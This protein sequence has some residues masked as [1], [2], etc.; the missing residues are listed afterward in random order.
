MRSKSE[1]LIV[2]RVLDYLSYPSESVEKFEKGVEKSRRK[3]AKN[4]IQIWLDEEREG[5]WDDSFGFFFG[6]LCVICFGTFVE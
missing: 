2:I 1:H 6:E 3:S 5:E 4:E